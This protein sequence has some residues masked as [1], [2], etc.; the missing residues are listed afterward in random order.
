VGSFPKGAIP[1]ILQNAY[2][3]TTKILYNM[4][5]INVSNQYVST[6]LG[7][8]V[9][10][11]TL[12]VN[13]PIPAGDS[14]PIMFNLFADPPKNRLIS[15]SQEKVTTS[16][17]FL[18][19]INVTATTATVVP[20]GS[21]SFATSDFYPAVSGLS[22]DLRQYYALMVNATSH[23]YDWFVVDIDTGNVVYH[24]ANWTDDPPVDL[25]YVKFA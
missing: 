13:A 16:E 1:Y 10:D 8:S 20:I 15:I 6:Y 7:I 4:M 3:P 17:Y 24:V 11:G 19:E 22:P 2:N 14:D 5:V 21:A 12:V 18:T 23:I 9:P 25:M